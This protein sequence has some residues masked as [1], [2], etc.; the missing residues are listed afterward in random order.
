MRNTR[1]AEGKAEKFIPQ[2]G[3]EFAD[4]ADTSNL[5]GLRRVATIYG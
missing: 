4:D 2:P 1:S 5:F 3:E